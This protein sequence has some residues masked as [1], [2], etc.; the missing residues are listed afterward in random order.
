MTT[1]NRIREIA[2][3]RRLSLSALSRR[4]D[5]STGYIYM[6][7][8]GRTKPGTDVLERIAKALDVPIWALFDGAPREYEQEIA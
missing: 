6:V 4:A 7:A 2:K 1:Y 3:E 5:V 8:N